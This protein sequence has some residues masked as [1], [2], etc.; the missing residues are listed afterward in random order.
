MKSITIDEFKYIVEELGRRIDDSLPDMRPFRVEFSD[1]MP[2]ETRR[3]RSG[4]IRSVFFKTAE[5]LYKILQNMP[6]GAILEG[7]LWLQS[8]Q[9]TTFIDPEMD[10]DE[11]DE[12]PQPKPQ[13]KE[14]KTSPGKALK[15]KKEK[16]AKVGSDEWG[17]F[18]QDFRKHILFNED[19]M[20]VLKIN[21]PETFN[22]DLHARYNQ[23]SLR[24]IDPE[25]VI[26]D[27]RNGGLKYSAGE[28]EKILQRLSSERKQM[29]LD[30]KIPEPGEESA[31]SG[32]LFS[33]DEWVNPLPG[34]NESQ[35]EEN[36]NETQE[37]DEEDIPF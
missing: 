2:S 35:P 34:E 5:D 32:P 36:K 22:V 17:Y 1:P 13:T 8:A 28:C 24:L 4:I 33:V 37:T 16:P 27:L 25:L 26:A 3:K 7:V 9:I 14:K 19:V 11:D 15:P 29:G 10:L 31:N 23:P 18:W 21:S 20:L 6:D 30:P 12:N